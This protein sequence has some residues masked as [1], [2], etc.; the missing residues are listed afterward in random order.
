MRNYFFNNNL[1][2]LHERSVY[3]IN[4]EN[5]VITYTS[6]EFG[7]VILNDISLLDGRFVLALKNLKTYEDEEQEIKL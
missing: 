3:K 2:I 7:S 5:G 1:I 6:F 4:L